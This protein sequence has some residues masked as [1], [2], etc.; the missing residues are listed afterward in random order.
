MFFHDYGP[1]RLI[2][3][4]YLSQGSGKIDYLGYSLQ[5]I[6]WMVL[7]GSVKLF[8]MSLG[9]KV[10]PQLSLLL[11]K[12]LV[13]FL[14]D[15]VHRAAFVFMVQPLISN[16]VTAFTVSGILG[17]SGKDD[18]MASTGVNNGELNSASTNSSVHVF[19]GSRLTKKEFFTP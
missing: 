3:G 5:V 8:L 19:E 7:Q 10:C 9:A 18:T 11:H 15:G 14:P 1:R 13:H 6:F 16:A 12:F 2:Y 4:Q 17:S